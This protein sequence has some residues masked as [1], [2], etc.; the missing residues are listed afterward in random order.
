MA[1]VVS[2]PMRND[3]YNYVF[4]ITLSSVVYTFT[5]RYNIRMDR[6]ILNIDDIAGNQ[7]LSGIPLLINYSLMAQYT[8]LNVLVGNLYAVDM[9]QNFIQ[10]SQFT[11]GVNNFL[12]Y[13]A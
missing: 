6:W 11:F 9:S 2:I 4:Q 13:I 5:V 12:V 7:I 3:I 10:P 8:T 1:T